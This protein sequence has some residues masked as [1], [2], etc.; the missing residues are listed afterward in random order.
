MLIVNTGSD[1]C[2]GWTLQVSMFL[3]LYLPPY[4]GFISHFSNGIFFLIKYYVETVSNLKLQ[5]QY[6]E[7]SYLFTPVLQLLNV[8]SITCTLSFSLHIYIRIYVY[9]YIQLT[10]E[11]M[12][13]RVITPCAAEHSHITFDCPKM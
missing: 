8:L 11:H 6:K 3:C 2:I 4:L 1:Y 10:F 9:I 12:R 5:R 7:F 13:L